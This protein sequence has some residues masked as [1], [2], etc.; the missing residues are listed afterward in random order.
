[1]D[2]A[3][4]DAIVILVAMVLVAAAGIGIGWGFGTTVPSSSAPAG[5]T[6]SI[7]VGSTASNTTY[8]LTLVEIMGVAWN[9][10]TMQPK[11]YVLGDHG[12]ESSANIS[13]P[14]HRL[15]QLTIFSYDTPTS[16]VSAQEAKVEG[17]VGGVMSF[18]NGT[19]ATGVANETM[20]QMM[21]VGMNVTS[22]PADSVAHTFSIP[23]LGI[24]VP[25]VGGSTEIAYLMFDQ[26]GNYTW[27]C[28]TPCGFGPDGSG[29][30]MSTPGWMTGQLTVS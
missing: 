13:L 4:N 6:S 12:L 22:V 21:S 27:L 20:A 2:R 26:T 25:V 14:A 29:G 11:F 8:K 5:P 10:T 17:T 28:M 1:M 18:Y 9:S 19:L 16:G 24:G 7:Q 15:V 23:Q 3:L 30:A